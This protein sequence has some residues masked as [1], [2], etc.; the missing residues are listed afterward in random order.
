M[1]PVAERARL[2]A[3]SATRPTAIVILRFPDAPDDPSWTPT[4]SAARDAVFGSSPSGE[5]SVRSYYATQTYGKVQ[6]A[7]KVNP[8]GDVFGPYDVPNPSHDPSCQF[9]QWAYDAVKAVQAHDHVDLN[10]Y[11]TVIYLFNTGRCFFAGLGGVGS[12]VW[13]NGLNRYTHFNP[14]IGTK[15]N[16]HQPRRLDALRR[17]EHAARSRGSGC[18]DAVG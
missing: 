4:A 8:A 3:A 12:Q 1:A 13:I 2:T 14:A 5:Y 9:T 16:R 6:L 18:S 10:T 17:A 7:G 15:R 11:Q